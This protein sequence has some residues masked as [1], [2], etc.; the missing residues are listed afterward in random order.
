MRFGIRAKFLLLVGAL[1][2]I[3]FGAITVFQI[4]TSTTSLRANLLEESKAFASLATQ[5]IGNVFAI[6]KDSGT[7]KITQ[8][9]DKFIE[10]NSSITNISVVDIAGKTAFS[11]Q[12]QA[13]QITEEEASNFEPI[14]KT[15][16]AGALQAI[17][18]PYFEASGAHRF[19]II[20]NVSDDEIE[21]AVAVQTRQLLYFGI[22]SLIAT[23]VLTYLLINRLIIKPI[24]KVSQQAGLISAGNL[25][26][27]ISVRSHDEIASLG[28]SV[29]KMAD[30]LKADIA[31][32]KEVDK[33]KSEFMMITSH[34]LR[35]PL[36]IINGYL[37][38][39]GLMTDITMLKSG[40]T[41]IAASAK[42]L[43]VF[44]EDILT[45]SQFELGNV[46][47]QDEDVSITEFVNRIVD[48]FKPTATLKE[49]TVQTEISD[50]ITKVHISRPHMRSA[51]WNILDNSV[52]FTPKGGTVH[53]QLT[54]NVN[55]VQ[56]T[57]S[58][59]GI[60]IAATEMPKLFTKFHRGTST[61][62][63]DYEGTGIGLYSSKMVV[64]RYGGNIKA[65]SQEGKGSTFTISLPASSS[66]SS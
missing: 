26:Q 30:F 16:E 5:P 63:Y 60:G 53:I 11:R 9:I 59:T 45:I 22:V 24:Q 31:K 36:S 41:K 43:D 10:L 65:T 29:N 44:A 50:L 46:E 48:E 13:E 62:N 39:M 47:L 57:I 33:V 56:L 8:E 15:N 4:R 35:T 55:Q 3:I 7:S 18:Y 32:L 20:Y 40:L 19:S 17:I 51:I 66:P 61:L 58:D 52:K 42:K 54:Q 2:F 27:Q 25:E 12:N 37:E 28:N 21:R 6:Y 34:N 1:L 14:Y 64:E 38:N 49:I 23:G